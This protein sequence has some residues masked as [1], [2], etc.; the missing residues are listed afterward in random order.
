MTAEVNIRRPLAPSWRGTFR[1][2]AG[3][4]LR[5]MR[6]THAPAVTFEALFP[7]VVPPARA[8]HGSA[9]YDARAYVRGRTIKRSDGAR[10]W[11]TSQDVE[12]T[13]IIGPR[14]TAMIPL[15]FKASVPSGYEAQVRIRSSVAFRKLLI[16]PNSPGTIDA[17][18]PDEWMVLVHNTGAA[19]ASVEHGE[20]IAQII[21]ARFEIVSWMAGTVSVSTRSGGVGSTGRF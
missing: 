12:D 17:D 6:M 2:A 20:R 16:V 8:T 5:L 18:Y 9:G 21:I 3:L 19:P 4:P 1:P 13:V 15:G 14:E 7:D 10:V 11:E